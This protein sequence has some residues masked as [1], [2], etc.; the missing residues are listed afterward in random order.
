MRIAVGGDAIR[1][2]GNDLAQGHVETGHGLQRQAVDQVDTHR[3]EFGL[4]GGG[5]QGVD[6]LF[7]LLTIDRRLHIRVEV[8]HAETQAIETELAQVFD[9]FGADG[10]G[11]NLNGEL[12]L[13]AVI[14]V[15]RLVQAVHQLGQLLAGQVGRCAATEVQLAECARAVEQRRLHGDLALEVVEV[16]DRAMGLLGDDLVA[17]AV[18]AKALAER[19]MDI[20]RQRLGRGGLITGLGGRVIVIHG[21]RL[22]ELRRRGIGGVAWPRTVIFLDQR[23]IETQRLI[24][25]DHLKA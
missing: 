3:L 25:F 2:Q 10:A 5:D 14:Q 9:L 16:L 23:A 6:L 8:L 13:V 21:K 24:H 17:G 15:E 18:V 20:Q 11:V 1:A 4:T 7:T 19:D 12:V 22:M